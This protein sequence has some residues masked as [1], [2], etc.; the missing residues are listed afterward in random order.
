M[1]HSAIPTPLQQLISLYR[2]LNEMRVWVSELEKP[3]DYR[4]HEQFNMVI[5]REF[6][7]WLVP[8]LPTL[9]H[10]SKYRFSVD[11][12]LLPGRHAI[13]FTTT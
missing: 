5:N 1:K 9:P 13:S 11:D 6:Y 7:D 10:L 4:P 12:N 8:V 3:F 2:L